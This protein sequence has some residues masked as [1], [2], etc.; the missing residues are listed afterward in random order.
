MRF[1]SVACLV[2][3]IPAFAVSQER[4]ANISRGSIPETLLRPA[5]GEAPRYPIDT[6]IGP[7]GQG[8]ASAAAYFFANSLL[9]GLLSGKMDHPSLVYIN[10][11]VREGYLSELEAIAPANFRIG[12]G[13]EEADGAVSFLIRFIGAEKGIVGELYIRYVTRQIQGE[14]EEVTTVGSWTFE[15]LI[16]EEPRDRDTEEKES[17]YRLD[18][19][20]Y[21]RFY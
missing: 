9:T 12:G 19:F 21:E 8:E 20:P 3:L 16:L 2:L 4:G 6:V 14:G 10:S 1:F 17:M 15:E 13:R 11:V 5:R 18:L 7:L